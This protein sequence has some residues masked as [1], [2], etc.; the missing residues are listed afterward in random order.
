MKKLFSILFIV[1]FSGLSYSQNASTFFP[2]AP[3]YR[4]FYKNTPLDSLNN[5]VPSDATFQIDS[6]AVNQDYNGLPASLVLSKTGLTSINQNLPFTDTSYF[7]FQSTNGYYYLNLLS[8][9]G[10]IPIID[11]LAFVNFLRSFEDWYSTYRFA[12]AVNSNY[13]IFTRDTTITF[14]TLTLPLRLS[15]TG[16]RLNDQTVSTVN[17]N[18]LAK[19]FLLT[20]ALSYGL[21]PPFIYIPIVTQPDT[22]YIAENVWVVKECRPSISVDLTSLG[23]PVSFTIPG[24]VKELTSGATGVISQTSLT[25]DDYRLYQNYPNPFNPSTVIRYSLIENGLVTLKVYDVLGNEIATL[26]NENQNSGTYNYQLSTVNYQL[27][28]GVYFYK[29]EAGDFSEVKRMILLK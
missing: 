22:S 27:S 19:K 7:N 8:F 14:D 24:S 25:A 23:F 16:R 9:I 11:S 4:W 12:Q 26:V 2:S 15:L 29:L 18:Y 21:L 20:F 28:S 10:S 6:F 5:P 1:L 17:G 3:G 13:T